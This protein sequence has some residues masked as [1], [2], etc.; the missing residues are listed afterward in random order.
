[1]CS[2]LKGNFE[3]VEELN[4]A[5][6]KDTSLLLSAGAESVYWLKT[7]KDNIYEGFEAFINQIPENTLIVCESNSLRKVVNPG[8]FVMVKNSKDSQMKKSA[9]DVI[10]QADIII[11]NNFNDDFQEVVKEIENI[12]N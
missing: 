8:V 10:D 7:L 9:S 2:S 6:N 3:I 5:N 1:M 11:K 4:A 12:I